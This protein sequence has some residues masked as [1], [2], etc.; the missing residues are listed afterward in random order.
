MKNVVNSIWCG[1]K[2]SNLHG[3]PRYHLKEAG[4]R[5]PEGNASVSTVTLRTGAHKLP[6]C[7]RGVGSIEPVAV[8]TG[9]FNF[10]GLRKFA[11][12]AAPVLVRASTLLS[13]LALVLVAIAA[14][15][16]LTGSIRVVDGDTV[17]RWIFRWRLAGLDAPEIRKAQCQAEREAGRAAAQRLSEIIAAG[18]TVRLAPVQWRLDKYGRLVGRLEVDGQDVAA[19][20]IA[21]GHA[22]PYDGRWRR[23]GWCGAP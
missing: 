3:L 22:R 2:D 20:L 21:D 7:S 5:E 1:R 18:R 10:A 6:D 8:S 23:E 15:H 11:N 19:I 16:D 13:R 9:N 4:W 14:I 17:D 12:R